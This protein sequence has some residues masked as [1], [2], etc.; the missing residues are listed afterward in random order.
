MIFLLLKKKYVNKDSA[1][2]EKYFMYMYW[3]SGKI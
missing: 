3:P 2:Y 1:V